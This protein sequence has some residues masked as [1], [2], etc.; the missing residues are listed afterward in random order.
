MYDNPRMDTLAPKNTV[1][2]RG[3][4]DEVPGVVGLA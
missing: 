4:N 3:V 2:L 1:V